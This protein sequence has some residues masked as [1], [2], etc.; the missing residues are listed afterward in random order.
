MMI[1]MTGETQKVRSDKRKP[2]ME[3]M[4]A[5]AARAAI[6]AIC[7]QISQRKAI[8][9]GRNAQNLKMWPQTKIIL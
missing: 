7:I 3:A 4:V 8:Y 1:K 5:M 9:I 6:A 2:K